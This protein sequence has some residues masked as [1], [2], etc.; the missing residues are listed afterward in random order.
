MRGEPIGPIPIQAPTPSILTTAKERTSNDFGVRVPLPGEV[1]VPEGALDPLK[2][3]WRTGVSWVSMAC[4]QSNIQQ[5]CPTGDD[6]ELDTMTP[7]AHGLVSSS[8][9]WMFT[10]LECEWS[11]SR[12]EIVSMS[13]ELTEARAAWGLGRALWMGDGLPDT[14]TDGVADQPTLRNF[15]QV[16]PGG[17]TATPLEETFALLLAAY[18]EGTQGLGGQVLHVPGPAMVYVLGA[19][20][21]GAIAK[22]EGNFYRAALGAVVSPG[23]GYPWGASTDGEDG[24]GPLIDDSPLTYT[25][26]D[27][28]ELWIYITGPI[29]YALSNVV[30]LPTGSSFTRQ[31]RTLAWSMRQLVYRFDPCS[32]WAALAEAPVPF[33][34]TS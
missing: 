3:S 33:V 30:E 34:E 9:F 7:G 15:A 26:N 1:E 6:V 25:G 16:A 2:A 10:P 4:A 12:N 19:G 22:Q 32:V 8:P 18:E 14:F 28:D 29:E 24:Y 27:N 17:D 31:N 20:S 13:A 23:P 5:Q 21:S 11:T